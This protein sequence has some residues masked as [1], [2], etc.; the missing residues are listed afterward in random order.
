[1]TRAMWE[2]A[3]LMTPISKTFGEDSGQCFSLSR[4]DEQFPR[5]GNIPIGNLEHNSMFL[6]SKMQ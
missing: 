5:K 2:M 1:M 3:T 4:A 6:I